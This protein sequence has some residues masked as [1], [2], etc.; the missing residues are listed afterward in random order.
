MAVVAKPD[1]TILA[2]ALNHAELL[3]ESEN[4]HHGL[5]HC[6]LFLAERN[7]KLEAVTNAAE[8]YIRFGEDSQLHADLVK[9]LD[10]FEEYEL[11]VETMQNPRFGLNQG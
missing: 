6:L 4:D 2:A 7:R 10:A 3:R 11:E 9:A 5:A 1:K 8:A